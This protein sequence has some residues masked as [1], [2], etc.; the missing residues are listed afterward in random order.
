M[1]PTGRFSPNSNVGET[2]M[3]AYKDCRLILSSLTLVVVLSQPSTNLLQHSQKLLGNP[4]QT[5]RADGGRPVPPLPPPASAS[6]PSLISQSPLLADGGR[7]VPPLPPPSFLKTLTADGGRPVPPLPPPS[8]LN[9]LT[10]DGG[11]PV[12][13]LP[14]PSFLNTLTADGGRPVPPLPPPSL[15]AVFLAA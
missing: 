13:P 7:P 4:A 9:T 12:P 1:L 14:P 6:L 10:A 15:N 3:S 2:I 11:R 5:Q 8:F